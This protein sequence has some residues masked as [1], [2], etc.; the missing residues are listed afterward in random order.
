MAEPYNYRG[1]EHRA[2]AMHNRCTPTICA[3]GECHQ[4]PEHTIVLKGRPMGW[5]A[6]CSCG[7]KSGTLTTSGMVAG[8][9]AN[10]LNAAEEGVVT[11]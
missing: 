2:D 11:R 8:W 3:C 1:D 5:Q 9:E 4:E 10:H 6:V 7:A